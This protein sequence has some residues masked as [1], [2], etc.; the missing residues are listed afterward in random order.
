MLSEYSW[1]LQPLSNGRV[2]RATTAAFTALPPF[3]ITEETIR[4]FN[5]KV[6]H[7]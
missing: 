6:Q 4:H 3:A 2:K 1:F 7:S 5:P